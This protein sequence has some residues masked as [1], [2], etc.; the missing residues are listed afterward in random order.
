MALSLPVFLYVFV[1]GSVLG[2]YLNSW[3]WRVSRVSKEALG[4]RSVCVGCERQLM[5]YENIP[6]LSFLALKGKCRTC[7]ITIPMDYFWLEA[8]TGLLFVGLSYYHLE[9]ATVVPAVFFRDIFFLTVLMIIFVYDA[10]YKIILSSLVWVAATVGFIF[11]YYLGLSAYSLLLGVAVGGGFFLAQ[12]L[13]S[14]GKWIGGGD[15]RMGVMMGAWLGWP[16][17]L[18][19]LFVSY[20]LGA[21]I[22]IPLLATKKKHMKSEIPFGTFLAV[23]TFVAMLWG[24]QMVEWYRALIGW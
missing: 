2:S 24:S 3:M 5:W 12:Y 18:V 8:F 11:N 16:G 6:L 21:V 10:K 20:I 19:A 14:K 17:I 1:L 22:A 15:V 9:Q 7:K 4:R 23:G 13:I